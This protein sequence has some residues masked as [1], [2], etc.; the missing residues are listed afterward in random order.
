ME[1]ERATLIADLCN[2]LDTYNRS[3]PWAS[4][5]LWQAQVIA[6]CTA[7]TRAFL[8]DPG[9]KQAM[10]TMREL[11]DRYPSLFASHNPSVVT[12]HGGYRRL[13]SRSRY[14]RRG[15]G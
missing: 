11:H 3:R 13:P 14:V 10:E 15:W 4:W 12:R 5:F 2:T 9:I 7:A 1:P 8:N 6:A